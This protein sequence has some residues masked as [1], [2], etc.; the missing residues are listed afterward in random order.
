MRSFKIFILFI[1]DCFCN[2]WFVLSSIILTILGVS[3]LYID[4]LKDFKYMTQ[5]LYIA[6]I[7]CCIAT[8][9]KLYKKI[10][11]QYPE[12][13]IKEKKNINFDDIC[14][15]FKVKKKSRKLIYK[16]KINIIQDNTK[17]KVDCCYDKC[18]KLKLYNKITVK[19]FRKKQLELCEPNIDLIRVNNV[20]NKFFLK[21]LG[22]SVY[23]VKFTK[24]RY[25]DLFGDMFIQDKLYKFPYII[26][27]K[28]EVDIWFYSEISINESISKDFDELLEWIK[29]IN[30]KVDIPIKT[31]ES[32]N[33]TENIFIMRYNF[34]K[35]LLKNMISKKIKEDEEFNR[36]LEELD[37]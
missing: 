7:L 18:V 9:F 34:E 17:F 37:K 14:T 20:E 19:N 10:A 23:K 26:K 21:R 2:F 3:S 27:G 33:I 12:V 29:S 35:D 4:M 16:Y 32:N 31:K 30:L 25:I 1:R 5:T 13:L 15:D 22:V 36:S 11:S 6:I 8:S 28:E 24:E